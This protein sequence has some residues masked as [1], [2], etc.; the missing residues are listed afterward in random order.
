MA[1]SALVISLS[2]FGVLVTGALAFLRDPVAAMGFSAHR[3]ERLPQVMGDRYASLCILA[4][5]ATLYGDLT[6]IAVFYGC[7]AF[8]GFA[9]SVI[10]KRAGHPIAKHM[11]AGI[12]ALLVAIMALMAP[13][14]G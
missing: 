1:L 8:I 5:G 2:A 4:L 13:Y 14:A 12:L 11:A 10:Y 9:D 6:V 7:F 3:A